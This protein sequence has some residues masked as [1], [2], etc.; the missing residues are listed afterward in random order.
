MASQRE[1]SQFWA[2]GP[3][4]PIP[5]PPSEPRAELAGWARQGL[6]TLIWSVLNLY[7]VCSCVPGWLAGEAMP[8]GREG[9][10]WCQTD[11]ACV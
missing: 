7:Q 3:T 9:E 8:A 2:L 6:L 5:S 4:L 10:R 11:G 1:V